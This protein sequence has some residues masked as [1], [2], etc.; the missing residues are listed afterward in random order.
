MEKYN[1]YSTEDFLDD[2]YFIAYCKYAATE[3]VREWE[4]WLQTNPANIADYEQAYTYL[5]TVLQAIRIVPPAYL[6]ETLLNNIQQGITAEEKGLYKR[7]VV[8]MLVT[9]VAACFCLIAA[10]LWYVNSRITVTTALGEHRIVTL[11]DNSVVTLNAQSSLTYYRA[12][13]WHKTREVWLT[14][15]GLFKVK[16]LNKDTGNILPAER[17]TAYAGA[18]KVQVLGTTFNIKE[19]R[20]QVAVALLEGKISISESAS[21]AS[22]YILEKGDVFNYGAGKGETSKVKQL[23]NQPAAWVDRK[24]VAAG[25]TVQDIINNYE[26]TYGIRIVLDNPAQAKKTIDGTISIG[27]DDNL[28]FMLANILN[29]DIERQGKVI[30]L[31]SR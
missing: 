7:R 5:T 13:W 3:V 12:W 26:D 1:S 9:G 27:T 25:M 24:I 14:G 29:A 17:F 10:S 30:Y 20:S 4:G 11:P 23:T 19:R 8:R 16:H 22:P 2:D 6:E 18:L 15:E 21:Q 28:L 31:R